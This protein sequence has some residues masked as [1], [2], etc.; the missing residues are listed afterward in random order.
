MKSPAKRSANTNE[1]WTQRANSVDYDRLHL[2]LASRRGGRRLGRWRAG[3]RWSVDAA[4]AA[5][6][7][8]PGNNIQ[9]RHRGRLVRRL[10]GGAAQAAAEIDVAPGANCLVEIDDSGTDHLRVV[11]TN[12]GQHAPDPGP[13]S[14]FELVGMREHTELVDA[15]RSYG[16]TDEGGWCVMLTMRREPT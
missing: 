12:D 4:R 16:P 11:V 8:R 3:R 5:R 2:K 10:L 13:G 15:E 14:G 9:P 6:C 1:N 7:L